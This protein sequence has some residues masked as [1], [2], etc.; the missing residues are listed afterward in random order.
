MKREYFV[1]I[2]IEVIVDEHGFDGVKVEALQ[3]KIPS[4]WIEDPKGEGC[5]FG[6]YTISKQSMYKKFCVIPL[7]ISHY[8]FT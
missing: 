2:H 1:E 7:V 4:Y 5:Q 8:P 6:Q 3:A